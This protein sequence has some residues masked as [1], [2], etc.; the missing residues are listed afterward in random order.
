MTKPVLAEVVDRTLE[1][2]SDQDQ[3]TL[4]RAELLANGNAQLETQVTYDQ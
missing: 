2:W 1:K 3:K 4:F